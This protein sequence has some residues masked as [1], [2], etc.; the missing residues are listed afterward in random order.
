[1]LIEK[2]LVY[3]C[4]ALCPVNE[5]EHN[6]SCAGNEG[7]GEDGEVAVGEEEV[8]GVRGALL[9]FREEELRSNEGACLGDE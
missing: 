3:L 7:E 2:L 9:G 6:D 4:S 5:S 8:G 1:M